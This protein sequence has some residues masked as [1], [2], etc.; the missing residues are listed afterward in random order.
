MSFFDSI[1]TQRLE[2]IEEYCFGR[3]S[4]TFLKAK[5]LELAERRAIAAKKIAAW[6]VRSP[7][8]PV[9][10]HVRQSGGT[11]ARNRL[12]EAHAGLIQ[13]IGMEAARDR[14]GPDEGASAAAAVSIRAAERFDP[15]VGARFST[16]LA[17]W[18][19][20]GVRDAKKEGKH[21][22]RCKGS[23]RDQAIA[24]ALQKAS[25]KL[26]QVGSYTEECMRAAAEETGIPIEDIRKSPAA[27]GADCSLDQP[28]ASGDGD[29][30]P[31]DMLVDETSREDIVEGRDWARKLGVSIE[32]A[33][34]QAE[35]SEPTP[36]AAN[37]LRIVFDKLQKETRTGEPI[38]FAEIR[39]ELLKHPVQEGQ[40][41]MTLQ[42]ACQIC[43]RGDRKL[44]ESLTGLDWRS[45]TAG[46]GKPAEK[47]KIFQA[48]ALAEWKKLERRGDVFDGPLLRAINEEAKAEAAR[49][50]KDA[51][52]AL[53]YGNEM[54]RKAGKSERHARAL[55]DSVL[56]DCKKLGLTVAEAIQKRRD[57]VI[58]AKTEAKEADAALKHGVETARRKGKSERWG[59]IVAD[60]LLADCKKLGLT[61]AE[62]LKHRR[63][64]Q[65]AEKE[66]ARAAAA[67]AKL[68][69]MAGAEHQ[70]L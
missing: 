44:L 11:F 24:R 12:I 17:L 38:T 8:F 20:F 5:P 54:A 31:L 43:A 55:A 47:M 61:V 23:D 10:E 34:S 9:P 39:D 45:V 36:E 32:R 4:S 27:R 25:V 64:N 19:S 28:F 69:H 65:Q 22:V 16:W 30:S 70:R 18:A 1:R 7:T 49:A 50:K 63:D 62:V 67:A 51:A 40:D 66:A 42:R 46:A 33:I 57:A 60:A 6:N 53:K 35:A 56:E 59:R 29:M 52:A 58:A 21:Q 2:P 68:A 26:V 13:G 14:I 3:T 41:S 48:A 37:R 15:E